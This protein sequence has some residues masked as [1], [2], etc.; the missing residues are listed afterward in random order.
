MIT[1]K[2]FLCHE[3]AKHNQNLF[4]EIEFLVSV[5]NLFFKKITNK[6]TNKNSNN[7][8]VLLKSN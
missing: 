8:L 1:Q 7:W 4:K 5:V 2:Q 6:Q 3:Y